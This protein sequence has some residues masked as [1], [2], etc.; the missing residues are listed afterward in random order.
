VRAFESALRSFNRQDFGAAKQAFELVLSKYADEAEV[1]AR[2]RT[3]LTICDQRLARTPSVPRS[4]DA[5]YDQGVFEFNRGNVREA[6]GFF[7]KALKNDPR[8]DYALYSIAAAHTRLE[9]PAKAIDALR[10]AIGLN[11]V[12]KAHARRD[13]DFASLRSNED[14]QQLVGY[15]FDLVEE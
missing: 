2:V 5:L 15:D 7:E 1:T 8:A 10:R 6:L 13:L 12:H 11:S 14:F 9:Q 3:Y 4:P